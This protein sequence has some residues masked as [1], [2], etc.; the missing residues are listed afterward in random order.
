ML[1]HRRA[2]SKSRF[3]SVLYCMSPWESCLLH[4][5][6]GNSG[7]GV[8]TARALA[9]AGAKVILTSRKTSA[10]EEVV[11]KLQADGVTARHVHI[12]L[13]SA[14]A[15]YVAV[16]AASSDASPPIKLDFSGQPSCS[17]TRSCGPEQRQCGSQA[18]TAG[19]KH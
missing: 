13:S 14:N 7:I 10:G 17:A 16:K 12:A 18:T 15:D 9:H 8:E 2:S 3:C 6:G 11:T 5:Q 4:L 19:E 1:V